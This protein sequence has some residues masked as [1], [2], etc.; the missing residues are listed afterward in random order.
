[1]SGQEFVE[2][3]A[4]S[5]TDGRLL[6]PPEPSKV[7]ADRAVWDFPALGWH[8]IVEL[9]VPARG[10]EARAE[11]HVGNRTTACD[12]ET[13]THFKGVEGPGKGRGHVRGVAARVANYLHH[14][15]ARDENARA[16]R[17]PPDRR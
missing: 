4:K 11:W 9:V 13:G 17:R 12:L 3:V 1:M 14:F 15:R 8:L 6:A 10:M 2:L 16:A 7:G 5:A